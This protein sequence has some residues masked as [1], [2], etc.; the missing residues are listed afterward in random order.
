MSASSAPSQEFQIRLTDNGRPYIRSDASINQIVSI[1]KEG[2]YCTILGPRYS[3]KTQL[4]KD[5]KETIELA[6][7]GFCILLDLRALGAVAGSDFFRA[8]A[9][10]VDTELK[11]STGA[12]P[13][14]SDAAVFDPRSL[15]RYLE[16]FVQSVKG[17]LVLL[18]NRLDRIHIA[19]LRSLLLTLG[20][21]HRER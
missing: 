8:F 11:E 21:T 12:S 10:L 6:K 19:S 15:Q 5:V 16:E 18:I 2:H 7:H 17:D 13:P 4:L 3:H 14:T 1:V 20:A 9:G